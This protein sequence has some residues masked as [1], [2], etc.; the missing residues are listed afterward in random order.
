MM[1]VMVTTMKISKGKVVAD[2]IAKVRRVTL[3]SVS[4][5]AETSENLQLMTAC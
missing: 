4:G 5:F 1:Q 3:L 2:A